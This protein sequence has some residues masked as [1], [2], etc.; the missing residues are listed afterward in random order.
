ML[1]STYGLRVFVSASP[2]QNFWEKICKVVEKK[3]FSP[4]T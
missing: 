3:F 2:G 1:K 4:K